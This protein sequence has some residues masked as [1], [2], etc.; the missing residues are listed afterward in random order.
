[1]WVLVVLALTADL[2]TKAWAFRSL[3]VGEVRDLLPGVLVLRLSLNPGAL[4]GLGPGMVGL[5]V[6]ASVAAVAFVG[7]LFAGSTRRQRVIHLALGLIL[8]GALGNLYDRTFTQYDL[9]RLR[10]TDDSPAIALLGHARENAEDS[11]VTVWAWDSTEA[12]RTFPLEKLAAPIRRVG[13]VRDF[14]KIT[15][16]VAGWE[17]WPWIFNVADALLVAGVAL[18]LIG[19]WAENRRLQRAV[20]KNGADAVGT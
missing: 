16:T 8:A 11:S 5:F 17:I 14:L 19:Y 3:E 20:E 6:V 10:S 9:V 2:W 18:L 12:P 15:P 1:M 7:F 4:F 13:V